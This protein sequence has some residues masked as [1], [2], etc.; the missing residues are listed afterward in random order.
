MAEGHARGRFD[1]NPGGLS[2]QLQGIM[3]RKGDTVLRAIANQARVDVP[4]KTGNLG[5]SIGVDPMT[6]TGAYSMT[7][8]VFAGGREAPYAIPVHEGSRP[9][10]IIARRAPMLSFYWVKVGRHVKFR[11]VNHPGTKPR[12]FLRNAAQRVIAA[13]PELKQ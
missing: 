13:D 4:V 8:S 6:S 5:R 9:H 2:E 10:K 1:L 11:S 3:R 12:P 7:G